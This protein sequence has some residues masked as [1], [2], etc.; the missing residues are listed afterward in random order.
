MMLS[1]LMAAAANLWAVD[2][3]DFDEIEDAIDNMDFDKPIVVELWA[4]WC[5]GSRLVAPRF[6]SNARTFGD[7][8]WFFKCDIDDNPEIVQYF[9][10]NMLPCILAIYIGYDDYGERK[11]FW[12]GARG[13]PY[14]KY[15]H[16][17]DIVNEAL[18]KHV[19]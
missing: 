15:S 5:P 12:T 17:K 18:S 3:I 1:L 13:E 11:V 9:N 7:K 16:I 14:L 2:Y 10:V 6:E 8:A 19:P 4:D